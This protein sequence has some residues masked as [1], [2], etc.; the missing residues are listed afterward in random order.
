MICVT[1]DIMRS[2]SQSY[3]TMKSSEREWFLTEEWKVAY[4]SNWWKCTLL[5]TYL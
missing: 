4:G 1:D 5:N 2:T 3:E